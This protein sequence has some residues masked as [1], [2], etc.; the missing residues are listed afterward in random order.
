PLTPVG[1]P[2]VPDSP[3]ASVVPG[4]D[5]VMCLSCHRPHGSPYA[6]MLRW[7]YSAQISG[8]PSPSET[9]TG[10]FFCHTTKDDG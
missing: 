5:M 6:D 10:C 9:H 1:R 2:N 7:D 8:E 4:K 3:S